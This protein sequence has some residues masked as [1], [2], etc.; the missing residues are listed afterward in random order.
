MLQLTPQPKTLDLLMLLLARALSSSQ[1][2]INMSTQLLKP[3]GIFLL[4]KGKKETIT[5]EIND[6]DNTKYSYT[7]HSKILPKTQRHI[8]EIKRK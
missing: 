3:N 4:M 8:L 1:N 2:I 5:N 6:L 7:I